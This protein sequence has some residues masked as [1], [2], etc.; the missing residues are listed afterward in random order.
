MEK[1]A[2]QAEDRP[3]G[4]CAPDRNYVNSTLMKKLL[5]RLI[6]VPLGVVLVVF[7]VANRDTVPLSLDP[8]DVENPAIATPPLPLWFWLMSALLIGFFSGA[9]GMWASGRPGRKKARAE[10]RELKTLKR[11]QA[12]RDSNPDETLPTLQAH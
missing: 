1:A 9:A 5:S 3:D 12:A 4:D 8:F 10:H 7:L 11:E 6:W 2:S